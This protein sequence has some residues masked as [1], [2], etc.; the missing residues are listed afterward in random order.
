M[1]PAAIKQY[2]NGDHPAH[3][4]GTGPFKFAGQENGVKMTQARN[5]GHFS[6][7]EDEVS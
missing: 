1:R 5:Q 2:G 4:F 3:A 7:T 6:L